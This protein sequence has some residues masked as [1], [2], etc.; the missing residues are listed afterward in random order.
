MTDFYQRDPREQRSRLD[1]EA[2]DIPIVGL[3]NDLREGVV[4]QGADGRIFLSNVAAE[5]ILGLTGE[6]IEG[7]TSTDPRWRAIREDGTDFP[8]GEHPA[9]VTLATG[10]ALRDVVMGVHKSDGTLTWI[11]I[12]SD[13]I[14]AEGE[15]HPYAVAA[16]FTDITDVHDLEGALE[17]RGRNFQR[18]LD[19][20]LD[21][22]VFLRADRDASGLVVDFIHEYANDAACGWLAR[23]LEQVVGTRLTALFPPVMASALVDSY[24]HVVETGDPLV[25]D[26]VAMAQEQLDGGDAR[27]DVRAVAVDGGVTVTWR[28]VSV[29]SEWVEGLARSE[30]RYRL[31]IDNASDVVAYVQQGFVTW[32]SPSVSRVLEWEP[33]ELMSRELMQIVHPDDV[34]LVDPMVERLN[35]GEFVAVRLR[36]MTPSG[37]YHWVDVHA[38]RFTT[39]AGVVDGISASVRVVDREV[40]AEADLSRRANHDELTGLVNRGVAINHV[41]S[42]LAHEPRTGGLTALLFCDIDDF[43]A[44]NDTYGHVAGDEVLRVIADRIEH[45]VRQGDLAARFGGDEFLLLLN[46]V[47][48]VSDAGRVAEKIRVRALDPIATDMGEV[49]VTMSIGVTVAT[50]HE[51]VDRLIARADEAMYAAKAAGKDQVVTIRR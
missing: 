45:V 2:S 7:R 9:M 27:F 24:R 19:S 10:E 17:A 38:Q 8:G 32:V 34:G 20:M 28:D 31:L 4:V 3:L 29:R 22:V 33:D 47:R 13:P 37:G 12:N 1:A 21:P 49:R 43:K 46:G 41:A 51:D 25:L 50:P 30:E 40:A 18:V 11:L 36:L 5:R 39:A 6:Q 14:C 35:R 26:N 15:T 16:F 44:V 42:T 23:E 48:D